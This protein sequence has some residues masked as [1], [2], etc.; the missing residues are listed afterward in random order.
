VKN[1]FYL[2]VIVVLS[3]LIGFFWGS[4][5]EE[6][7][8]F[9]AERSSA[10]AKLNLLMDYVDQR[11]VDSLDIDALSIEVIQEIID[12][13]DPH[14]VYIP[15]EES[16][17]LS[18]TMQG[19][20]VGI[21]VSFY[22]VQDTVTIVRVLEGGPSK[23]AGI[24]TGDRILIADTDTL[25]QKEFQIEDIVSKL[26]GTPDS[27]VNLQFY[28]PQND[29][30]FS[31]TM[32]RGTVPLKSVEAHFSVN[33]TTGYIKINRFSQTTY[34]EFITALR[35]FDLYQTKKLILDLRDNPGGYMFPAKQIA[36]E[37]LEDGNPIVITKSNNGIRQQTLATEKGGYEK[38][39]VYVLL[40]EQSASA[41]EVLAGALQDNDRA[42]IVGRR[43]FGKGL[44]QQQ[45]P[46]GDGDA[47]RLTTARYYTPTG[48]SIQRPYSSDKEA[49][50]DEVNQ[51][52]DSGEMADVAKVPVNDTLVYK[53]PGGRTVYGGGG[54]TPD[55]YVP[56]NNTRAEE[57]DFFLLRSNLMNHFVFSTIDEDRGAYEF[58]SEADFIATPLANTQR[59]IQDFKTYCKDNGLPLNIK[60]TQ[61]VGNAIKAYLGLQLFG[62][63]CYAKILTQQDVF[64]ERALTHQSIED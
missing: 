23:K 55:I 63:N 15:K 30:L 2:L 48:R 46:L 56:N 12:R 17:A 8:L 33:E 14:T 34:E 27:S 39:E 52:Y 44:V 43:S 50:Y 1:T 53:T 19:N 6:L 10:Q 45:L 24:L 4:R 16:Q 29:S 13:L 38:G 41:A 35:S 18:E 49:Y 54:I 25:Y 47:V 40:N 57:F 20:F 31:L 9:S 7:G 37:F 61:I 42:W 62:E 36:D 5:S 11:Y 59:W 26:K 32:P 60:D 3:L 22:M 64:I 51:R 58:A 28:R 21:G